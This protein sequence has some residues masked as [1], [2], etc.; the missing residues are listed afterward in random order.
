M[1]EFGASFKKARQAKNISLDQ[2]AL[3][4]RISTRFLQAIENEE[5]HLL[6]GGI[7]NRGFVRAFAERI[8]LDPEQAVADYERL[9]QAQEPAELTRTTPIP[10]RVD[11]HLYPI[12]IGALVLLI[13]IF[14]A[15]S[16][17]SGPAAE[18]AT[19]VPAAAPQPPPAQPAPPP[20]V[21]T[22]PEIPEQLIME[23][24]V[25]G[26]TWIRIVTDDSPIAVDEILQ[27]GAARRFT[28]EKSIG[29][30]IGNAGGITLKINGEEVQRLGR[31]GQVREFTV[32]L[33]NV[34]EIIAGNIR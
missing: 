12:A 31:S 6:P 25:R 18:T 32:T 1:T 19:E 21:E 2:I 24:D 8:G 16:R 20:T 13:I 5:F 15:V 17:N 29:V 9:A 7:F 27:A 22:Q 14:Y 11:R 4:T 28:A 26:T 30:A 33:E 23:M 10:E 34:K 3:E